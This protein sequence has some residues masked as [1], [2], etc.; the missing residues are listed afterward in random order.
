MRELGSLLRQQITSA[1]SVSTLLQAKVDMNFLL[2][3]IV[4]ITIEVTQ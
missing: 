1:I 3:E 2:S 4:L